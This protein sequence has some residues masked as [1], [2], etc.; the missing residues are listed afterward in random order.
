MAS[1]FY[2]PVTSTISTRQESST[3]ENVNGSGL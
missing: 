2:K 1:S 3:F